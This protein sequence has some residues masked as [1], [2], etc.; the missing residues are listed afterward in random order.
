LNKLGASTTLAR[1][2]YRP[3]T[4]LCCPYS[5]NKRTKRAQAREKAKRYRLVTRAA[6]W[7]IEDVGYNVFSPITH[8]HPLHTIADLE[9]DW[10]TWQKIDYQ[11][12]DC[13]SRVVVLCIPGWRESIGV[14]AELKY[15]CEHGLDVLYLRPTPNDCQPFAISRDPYL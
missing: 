14:T 8:S 9:G 6:A 15:A 5:S 4:Y 1:M 7:L 12:I 10:A 3:L 2:Q 11:Y 13:S